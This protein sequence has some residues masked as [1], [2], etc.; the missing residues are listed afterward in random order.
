M[1]KLIYKNDIYYISD[2]VSDTKGKSRILKYKPT[3]DEMPHKHFS[4]YIVI[5]GR[6]TCPYCIKTIELLKKH[7]KVLFVEIDVEPTQLFAKQHLLEI[8]KAEIGGHSTVPIVFDKGVFI[9]GASDVE[10]HF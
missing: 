6:H 9:G 7:S 2:D 10:K 1:K 4:K 5:Y 3:S 8:L